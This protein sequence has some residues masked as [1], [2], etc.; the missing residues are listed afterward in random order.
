MAALLAV[1][2]I[3]LGV[4]VMFDPDFLETR[5]VLGV[6]DVLLGVSIVLGIVVI[7]SHYD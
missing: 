4:V 6:T 1:A 7:R 5:V 3:V 2:A